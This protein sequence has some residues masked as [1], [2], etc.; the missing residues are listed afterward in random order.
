MAEPV[1]YDLEHGEL[2]RL[3]AQPEAWR[4]IRP[5]HSCG[6]ISGSADCL[7]FRAN[8]PTVLDMGALAAGTQHLQ[9]LAPSRPGCWINIIPAGGLLLIPEAS[10]SCVCHY[11]LQTSMAFRPRSR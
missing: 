7:F 1:L 8:N 11:S 5:G 2:V 4:L 9:K 3:G 6:T 10:A